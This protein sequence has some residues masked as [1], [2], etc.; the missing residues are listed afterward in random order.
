MNNARFSPRI[1]H[2][3]RMAGV[4]SIRVQLSAALVA[5]AALMVLFETLFFASSRPG[6]SHISNT[7]SEL[8]ETG[9][10][11]AHQVAFGFFLPVGL[12]VWLALWLVHREAPDKDV[13]LILVAMSCL[14]TGYAIAAVFP[15][16]PGAPLFGS[17]RTQ[18]HNVVGFMDYQGTGIGFLLV[19]CYFARR[20]ATIQA[21]AYLVAGALVLLG[22]A[23][24]SLDKTFHVRGVIQRATE[25]IQFTGLFFICTLLPRRM[26][27][28]KS[29]SANES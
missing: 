3:G 15:C 17:W 13:S 7:I 10:S 23:L 4:V 2:A 29:A 9:A 12:L 27:P 28:N 1:S 19:S 24:L 20:N 18:V 6:Y 5:A 25:V 8:G 14:G 21:A 26:M 11:C 16:D 22:L